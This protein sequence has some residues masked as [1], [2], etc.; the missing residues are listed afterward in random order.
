MSQN[1]GKSCLIAIATFTSIV[2][3]MNNTIGK[4]LAMD[5]SKGFEVS[6]SNKENLQQTSV[7]IDYQDLKYP[8]NLKITIPKAN[9]VSGTIKINDQIIQRVNTSQTQINLSSYIS[10][11]GKYTITIS[12]FYDPVNASVSVEYSSQNNQISQTTGGSG[13]INKILIVNVR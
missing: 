2:L 5:N 1:L 9:Q 13:K 6:Q 11:P 4:T 12:G 7:N 3:V 10:K 8:Q